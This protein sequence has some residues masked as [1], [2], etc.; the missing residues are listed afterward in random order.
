MREILLEIVESKLKTANLFSCLH[1]LTKIKSRKTPV[2]SWYMDIALIASYWTAET[3]RAYH[4][5]APISL[6]F[7][8]YEAL[9][10]IAEEG[11]EN[12]W[13]RHRDNA[14]LLWKGLEALGLTM[15]VEYAH[16]LP[17]LTTVKIPDNIDGAKVVSFLLTEHNIEISGG[18][19]ELAGKVWRIGF[20]GYNSRKENVSRLLAAL[21]DALAQ[22]HK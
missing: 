15:H 17:T 6:N 9:R 2:Q 14:E 1:I 16:R 5:T 22:A 18:L 21:K 11:L 10:I 8:L 20:M 13:G 12:R 7:A 4:H 19:G 3:K